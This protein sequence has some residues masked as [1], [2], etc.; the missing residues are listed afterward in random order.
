MKNIYFTLLLSAFVIFA[1]CKKDPTYTITASAGAGGTISPGGVTTVAEGDSI[2]YTIT[3]NASN[4][5]KAIKVDGVEQPIASVYKFKNITANH[6]IKAEFI[7]TYAITV[8]ATEGGTVSP[9]GTVIV[10]KGETVIFTFTPNTGYIAFKATVD[11]VEKTFSDNSLAIKAE[12]SSPS[13]VNLKIEF[14][15]KNILLMSQKPWE[16]VSD[17]MRDEWHNG[18]WIP[19]YLVEGRRTDVILSFGL[20]GICRGYFEDGEM[21]SGP[22]KWS[23]VGTDLTIGEI[24]F[25]VVELDF[26]TG[27][28]VYIWKQEISG[29]S[30]RYTYQQKK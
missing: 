30:Y 28:L 2:T 17:E 6:E 5:T 20:D 23:L 11:G 16:F 25:Q 21:S 14:I 10:K 18:P 22:Y 19:L 29:F 15:E 12:D 3:P 1:G 7:A 4:A 26:E 27:K 8:T 13:K 24:K 9:S